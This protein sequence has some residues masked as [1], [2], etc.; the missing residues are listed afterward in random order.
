MTVTTRWQSLPPYSRQI[1]ILFAAL[2]I[3]SVAI[4]LTLPPAPKAPVA[5][6]PAPPN[7]AAITDIPAMK[8][9]FFNYLQPIINHHNQSLL[10]DRQR[11]LSINT[12]LDGLDSQDQ[13]WLISQKQRY[14]IEKELDVADLVDLLLLRIDTI[15]MELVLVQAAKESGWGRSRFAVEAN[16]YFGQWC[17]RPGCGLIP[18][19]RGANKTHEVQ[20]FNS[21]SD[22]VR[23]YMHNI[24]SHPTYT[25]LRKIRAEYRANA[26][27]ADGIVLAD[28]LLYYSE[29]REQ[30]VDEVKSMVRQYR[31]FAQQQKIL[32]S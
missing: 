8:A 7:F 3:L 17:Y 23:S 21:V 30:Y 22:A 6:F 27:E 12:K 18:E 2:I 32:S 28:G 29:R 11:L 1:S 10:Q 20:K 5:E 13:Q 25:S 14:D 4:K 31:R 24:N 15:P 26:Q 19:N 16:N 9:A